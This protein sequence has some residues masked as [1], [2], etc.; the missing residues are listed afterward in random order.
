MSLD[1]YSHAV[2][3]G[4]VAAEELLARVETAVVV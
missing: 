4:E 2:D 1:V 3:P